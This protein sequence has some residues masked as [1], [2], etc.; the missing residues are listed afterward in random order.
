MKE[1][2][3]S[4]TFF[5]T[6]YESCSRYSKDGKYAY[7]IPEDG[8]SYG[9]RCGC[10]N[11]ELKGM[12]ST[13]HE[14]VLPTTFKFFHVGS[15]SCLPYLQKITAY[16]EFEFESGDDSYSI[17]RDVTQYFQGTNLKEICV[18]PWLVDKY[19]ERFGYWL[20]SRDAI[21]K[22]TAIPDEIA[23]KMVAPQK[24]GLIT[25]ED[26]RTLVKVDNSI[27]VLTIPIE[28]ERVAA[29]AIDQT[30][31]IKELIILGDSKESLKD[32]RTLEFDKEAI[33]S[34][35]NV[36]TLIIQWP[37]FTNFYDNKIKGAK[38]PN[39][40]TVIYPLWNYNHYC[41]RGGM[42][43]Y[44]EFNSY[45]VKAENF[46]SVELFEEDGIVYS[47]D[48]KYLVSGIDCKTKSI[49]IKDGVEEIF[50]Y[51]F[52]K[53]MSIEEVYIP[54]TVSKVGTC[55]FKLC[56]NIK[57]IIFNFEYVTED[58]EHA[59]FTYS[60][61]I[62]FYL[63]SSNLIKV[64]KNQYD[65]LYNHISQGL[66]SSTEKCIKDASLN[67]AVHVLP[68]YS[69]EIS[70][71]D[72]TGYV[73]SEKGDIFVGIVEDKAKDIKS[74]TLPNHITN[75]SKNAFSHLILN[76]IEQIVAPDFIQVKILYEYA[77]LCRTLKE[78][79]AGNEKIIIEN[80]IAYYNDYKE[81]IGISKDV[82]IQSFVCKEGVESIATSA[83][84]GHQELTSIKLSQTLKY[85]SDRAFA[86]TG[87]TEIEFPTSI[88]TIGKE[89]F[90]AC[91]LSVVRYEG[92]IANGA[93]AYDGVIFKSS[94]YIQ[95]Q[96]SHKDD[97]VRIYPNLKRMVKTPLPKWLRW[98]E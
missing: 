64:I 6:D 53:N 42:A 45:E 29:S 93:N 73:Y 13:I 38:I 71:D 11:L 3:E 10:T 31:V 47:K 35:K 37:T 63:P 90:S 9:L 14:L 36:E 28:I 77:K 67:I 98:L 40:K 18:L 33:N 4:I 82:K 32:R 20:G 92:Q 80:G 97:F 87:I 41:F 88:Q 2:K 84:E 43:E 51:A 69:G 50:Q 7:S 52:C 65:N 25:S 56:K 61:K 1:E 22:V 83:F 70:V 16:S 19:K 54:R 85:I 17:V 39:L 75:V 48:G 8:P 5:E 12:E 95:M 21:I 34:L 72:S 60:D 55:A 58:A 68:L 78:I 46:S 91:T 62:D 15:L 89:V 23:F 24:N 30:N 59:F 76:K 44:S 26:G 49:R 66:S 86:N 74:I 57:K 94:A 81:I 79:V 96:K 27:K